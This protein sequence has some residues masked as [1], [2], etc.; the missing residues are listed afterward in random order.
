MCKLLDGRDWW[1]EKLDLAL[2][3]KALLSKALLQLSAVGWGCAPLLVVWPEATQPGVYWTYGRVNGDLQEVLLKVPLPGLLLPVPP[4]R[5]KPLL[6]HTSTG[7]P[8]TLAGR[9]GS[10]S[11]GV[12]APFPWVLVHAR[13]CFCLSTVKSVSPSPEEVL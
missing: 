8:P 7:D 10:V 6:I 5:S 12:T 13:F 9:S 4:S 11:C 1:W 3:G 2:V